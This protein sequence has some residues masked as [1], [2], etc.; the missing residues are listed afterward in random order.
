MASR[1]RIADVASGTGVSRSTVSK[2][3]NTPERVFAPTRQRVEQ[4][5]ED[6]NFERS[7]SA[8]SLPGASRRKSP[9][10]SRKTRD[11]PPSGQSTSTDAESELILTTSAPL[12]LFP[13]GAHVKN[14]QNGRNGQR[15][16][17]RCLHARP[18]GCWDMAGRWY[19]KAPDSPVRPTTIEG[20]RV[21]PLLSPDWHA[22]AT[23]KGNP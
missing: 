17:S 3:L 15:W 11:S 10:R 8:N 1:P 21:D 7:K 16:A 5:I 22:G 14:P 2:V 12:E 19:R 6:L 13:P 4:S 9:N 23:L 18:I 20:A